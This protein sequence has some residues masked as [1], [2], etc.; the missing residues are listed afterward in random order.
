MQLDKR[1]QNIPMMLNSAKSVSENCLPIGTRLAEFEITGLIGEGGFGTVYLA[2]DHA[3]QRTVAIKEY[4]PSVLASRGADKSVLVG[5]QRHQEAF[6]AGLKSF[7]NEARLLAQFDHP[8]LIKVFRFWEE[9]RTGYI[10]MRYYEGKTLKNTVKDNPGIVEA[11]WLE[12]SV[13]QPILEALEAL[14]KVQILH[15]DISPD[16]IMI[17]KEGS[18]VLLDFGAARQ[19]IGDMTQ[20]LTVILKPGY[21]PVEQYA[22]DAAMKQGPWT[23]IYA[24]SAVIYSIIAKKPPATSVARMIKDPVVPLQSSMYPGF[25][26]EFLSA[27]NKGF[28][29]KPEDRPQSVEEFRNLLGLGSSASVPVSSTLGPSDGRTKKNTNPATVA[30][31]LDRQQPELKPS[32]SVDRKSTSAK[33][34]WAWLTIAIFLAAGFGAGAY[35]F[36]NSSALD[37]TVST[38]PDGAGSVTNSDS[39]PVK[40]VDD[41][42]QLP[43]QSTVDEETVAWEALNNNYSI[44]SAELT[45]F[46]QRFPFGK[47]ADEARSR[48]AQ[49]EAEKT[50]VNNTAASTSATAVTATVEPLQQ[51]VTPKKIE[52]GIVT[53]AVNPWGTVLVDGVSKG[54]S[55][56]LRRLALP[57]GTHK[58]RIVNPNFSNDY[59]T[60]IEINKKNSVKIKY[61]F[62]Q[63]VK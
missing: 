36:F 35:F 53:L 1:T 44:T 34:S 41:V 26:Q 42:T 32:S 56:P 14:H 12:S 48:L 28:S 25:S 11:A 45:S 22:D 49:I 46:I 21:A 16:N 23:D 51:K 43:A 20:A 9:N 31:R 6:E 5:S 37:T 50:P 40:P 19:V 4:M 39:V 27:I 15:R 63:P 24:L 61:D 62:S 3:L 2:F 33:R 7:I 54:V 52:T 47:H 13:M 17:Q 8:A 58:I 18:A 29:V 38:T 60:E 10:A 55:P 30:A 59:E 57:E